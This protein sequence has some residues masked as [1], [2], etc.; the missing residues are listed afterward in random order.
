MENSIR[1]NELFLE[2][3]KL[4]E[5]I[6]LKVVDIKKSEL[7]SSIHIVLIIT[8]NDHTVGVDQCAEAH[9]LVYPRLTLLE[10]TREVDL[11]VSTPGVQ[12]NFKDLYEF[13][14]FRGKRCRLYDNSISN[15]VEGIINEL[16]DDG[17]ELTNAKIDDKKESHPT[18]KVALHDIKKAKLAYSWEDM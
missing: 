4:L 2:L 3:S 1:S 6:G 12:R 17:V 9:R 18:Y 14:L 16:A 7:R 15:W 5:A 11:E 8:N 10:G 13:E